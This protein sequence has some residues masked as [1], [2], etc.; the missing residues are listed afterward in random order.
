MSAAGNIRMIV[1]GQKA[2]HVVKDLDGVILLKGGSGEIDKKATP[3]L[4]HISDGLGYYVAK[5]FPIMPQVMQRIGM[6]G[7]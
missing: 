1:D 3:K 7:T 5:E 6:T 2:P 4:S